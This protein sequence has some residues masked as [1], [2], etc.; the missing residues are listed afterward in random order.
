MTFIKLHH[1]DGREIRIQTAGIVALRRSKCGNKTSDEIEALLD[2]TVS[3]AIARRAIHG[4]QQ[5]QKSIMDQMKRMRDG[6]PAFPGFQP[7]TQTN[8]LAPGM[9]MAEIEKLLGETD[10]ADD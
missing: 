9:S 3:D 1:E 6:Q 10:G 5:A 2:K 4:V 8:V 7:E